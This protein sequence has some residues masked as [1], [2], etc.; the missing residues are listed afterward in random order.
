MEKTFKFV[1]ALGV[2]VFCLFIIGLF[3]LLIK[4]LLLFYPQI[5]LMGIT[6]S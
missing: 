6:M 1:V 5:Q 2:L 4:I 3:L